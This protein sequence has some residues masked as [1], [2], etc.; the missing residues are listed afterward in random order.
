MVFPT[1]V[2]M[3]RYE[4]ARVIHRERF[5]HPRGDGPLTC[6]DPP[7][8][9]RFSPPTWGWTDAKRIRVLECNVF[10]TH[11]GMD[12]GLSRLRSGR[13]CFP[14]PRG[15]GP[16]LIGEVTES[17]AF[18]PPTWGSAPDNWS[19]RDRQKISIYL[20]VEDAKS[21]TRVYGTSL[22]EPA[23]GDDQ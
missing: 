21:L 10:P 8:E 19:F 9:L 16:S 14:H 18:S 13:R 22:I 3:D 23:D 15:D 5:P 17:L 7:I 20:G 2:G 11:V 6:G 4:R 1:H 12:H